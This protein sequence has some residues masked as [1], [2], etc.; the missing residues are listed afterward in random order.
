MLREQSKLIMQAHKALD[1][2]LTAAAFIA[3]YFTKRLVLP[4][5]F[6][7]LTITPNY[8]IILLLVII[9][10]Y[11]VFGWFDL[12]ASYRRKKFGRIF[13]D[14]VKG[15]SVGML[16]LTLGLYLFRIID[17]SRIMLGLFFLLNVGF[18]GLSKGTV[19]YMLERY[20]KSGFNFRSVL[21]I[22]SRERA[23]ETIETIG[24]QIGSGFRVIGCLDI[25]PSDIGKSV[26]NGIKVF[27]TIDQ[28]EEI[29]RERVVDEV[30]FAMPLKKIE[31]ADQYIEKAETMGI[32]VRIVPDWQIHAL[33]YRPGN[34]SIQFEDFLGV[35]TMALHT[36][37]EHKG[38][39]LIKSTIDYIS[40]AIGMLLLL[41]FFGSV[42]IA[43][44]L[45]SK[46][47]VFLNRSASA[48]TVGDSWST[49]SGPW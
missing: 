30:I 47:A 29:L 38:A 49:S 36:T 28:L 26:S 8:Y 14:M 41:L 13:W 24:D 15:V 46:G 39:M 44:K 40:T 1:I 37:P 18:L 7:G 23:K 6:R 27:G 12:Y 17:V 42:A 5:P 34:A 32:S 11:I 45:S 35:R 21:I 25:D 43:I 33:M 10:W 31:N 19:Y 4:T 22:G 3:A 48:V 20:R 16:I 9:I 2:C